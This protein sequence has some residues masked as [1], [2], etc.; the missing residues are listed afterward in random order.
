MLKRS[1]PIYQGRTVMRFWSSKGLLQHRRAR[2]AAPAPKDLKT[3]S[4]QL[5]TA[6]AKQS[7]PSRRGR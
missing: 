7:N 2:F 4:A 6:L 5:F 3:E 1:V